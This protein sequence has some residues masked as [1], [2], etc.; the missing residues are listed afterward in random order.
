MLNIS[1]CSDS[2]C[3]R[4]AS[5]ISPLP[6]L[7]DPCPQGLREALALLPLAYLV[8]AP[9]TRQSWGLDSVARTGPYRLASSSFLP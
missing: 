9:H 2:A 5:L 7:P 4:T 8:P 3:L 6:L 1:F